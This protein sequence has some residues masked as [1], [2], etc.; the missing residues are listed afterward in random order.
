MKAFFISFLILLASCSTINRDLQSAISFGEIK[1]LNQY[2]LEVEK[3]LYVR[4]YKSPV[5]KKGCFQETHGICQYRYFISVS[6]FDEYPET[7]IFPLNTT[8]V[9]TDIEW[10]SNKGI[11]D[12]TINFTMK[13][14]TEIAILNN[15]ELVQSTTM[16]KVFLTPRS[17]KETLIG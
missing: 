5:Y 10:K 14:Y 15:P 13:R 17:K 9:I 1:E 8:G 16:V 4:L 11:D 6:T 7:N 3:Q 12:A 2:S